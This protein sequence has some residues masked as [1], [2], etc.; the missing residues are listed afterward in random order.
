M[1]PRA[2]VENAQEEI[3]SEILRLPA[4]VKSSVTKGRRFAV[5]MQEIPPK[6]QNKHSSREGLYQQ[7]ATDKNPPTLIHTVPSSICKRRT[8]QCCRSLILS[9]ARMLSCVC[10][11]ARARSKGNFQKLPLTFL[12]AW[13]RRKQRNFP[14]KHSKLSCVCS[15]TTTTLWSFPSFLLLSPVCP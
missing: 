8:I 12:H 11:A 5:R 15:R 14:T 9:G 7:R 4:S 10:A 1:S 3:I 13:L 2:S 6:E